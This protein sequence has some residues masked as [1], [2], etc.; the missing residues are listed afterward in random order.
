M[1]LEYLLRRSLWAICLASVLS[2]GTA[3]GA[4]EDLGGLQDCSVCMNPDC[5]D[6]CW[7]LNACLL[8]ADVSSCVPER[9]A[10]EI[11]CSRLPP[12]PI[13]GGGGVIIIIPPQ[14]CP[15]GQHFAEGGGC[16]DD[17]ECG[18]DEIGGGSEE[19]ERCG[20]GEVPNE[21]GTACE[22]CEHG[23]YE[24]GECA[25]LCSNA[26]LDSAAAVSL[27]GIPREPWE[28]LESYTCDSAGHMDI[29]WL[30]TSQFSSN[31]CKVRETNAPA[32]SSAYGHSHPHFVWDRDR[33]VRCHSKIIRTANDVSKLNK[34]NKDFGDEDISGARTRGKPMYL[35]VPERDE[36]WVYRKTGATGFWG[37]AIWRKEKVQ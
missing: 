1:K 28:R 31:A 20:P 18:D 25:S 11:C 14:E 3:H 12:P 16:E 17:H 35:V 2:T 19:C 36:V 10:F 23:E 32:A 34:E 22:E 6:E 7:D 15:A 5:R 4:D 21:D 26:E 27:G 8:A 13:G 24:S 9:T 37:G 33:G 30:G 29:R